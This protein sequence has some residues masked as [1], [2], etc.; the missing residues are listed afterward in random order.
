MD[1]VIL[2]EGNEHIYIGIPAP[3]HQPIN[4]MEEIVPTNKIEERAPTNRMEMKVPTVKMEDNGFFSVSGKFP[5]NISDDLKQEFANEMKKFGAVG[6][7]G[8]NSEFKLHYVNSRS[9]ERASLSTIAQSSN[10][11]L[12]LNSSVLNFPPKPNMEK[13]PS[14]KTPADLAERARERTPADR[15]GYREKQ[16][17]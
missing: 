15:E 11:N 3:A 1:L 14:K 10:F 7:S 17:W 9:A 4:K 12:K 6:F 5:G 16:N 8:D 13:K 2:S